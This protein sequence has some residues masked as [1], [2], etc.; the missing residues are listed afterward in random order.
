MNINI[1]KE[2]LINKGLKE[3]IDFR[4]VYFNDTAEIKLI[5]REHYRNDTNNTNNSRT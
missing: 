4:I 1:T 5:K 2:Q 3:N